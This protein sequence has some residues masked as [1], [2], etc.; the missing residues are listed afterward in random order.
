ML[1]AA[2][3][4]VY[5]PVDAAWSVSPPGALSGRPIKAIPTG[6]TGKMAAIKQER[7]Y[8]F[9]AYIESVYT[10]SAYIEPVSPTP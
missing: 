9:S 10:E 6:N 4:P 2:S 1:V 3:P 7:A 5:I 8:T